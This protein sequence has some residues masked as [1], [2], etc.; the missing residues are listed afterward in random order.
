MQSM[1]DFPIR[2]H[3]F[4]CTC[5]STCRHCSLLGF[6]RLS[7]NAIYLAIYAGIRTCFQV[8][9]QV[10]LVPFFQPRS[11]LTRSSR[12]LARSDSLL[13]QTIASQTSAD[14]HVKKFTSLQTRHLDAFSVRCSI[15]DAIQHDVPMS[16]F[17]DAPFRPLP[18]RPFRKSSRC[19]TS[20]RTHRVSEN[21]GACAPRQA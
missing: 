11:C 3:V 10:V 6:S 7:P 9:T 4:A 1:T 20:P 19:E 16:L 17:L 8:C 21:R 18:R 15:F 14:T 12:N 5:L 13:V 2:F